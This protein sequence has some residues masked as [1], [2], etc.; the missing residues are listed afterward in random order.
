MTAITDEAFRGRSATAGLSLPMLSTVFGLTGFVLLNLLALGAAGWPLEYP[1]D[2]VYIHLAISAEIA[3]GG[4]GVNPGEAS[5]AASSI[6]YPLLLTPLAGTDWH[7]YLPLAWN[8]AAVGAG[9]WLWGRLVAMAGIEGAGLSMLRLL[10]A[11]L[12]PLSFNIAGVGFTGME[13][14]LHVTATL[15]VLVGLVAFL[16]GGRVG[17]LLVA[18]IVLGPALRFEGVAVSGIA[19]A[20]L[21]F[22]GRPAVAVLAGAGALAPLGIFAWVLMQFGLDPVP[23]SVQAKIIAGLTEYGDTPLFRR[24]LIVLYNVTRP[25]GAALALIAAFWAIAGAAVPRLR[26]G[27]DLRMLLVLVG[28]AGAHLVMGRIGWMH[29]YEIYMVVWVMGLSI[30]LAA[31]WLRRGGRAGALARVGCAAVLAAGFAHYFLLMASVGPNAA[32]AIR[33]QQAQ[34]AR[35]V[36]QHVEGVVAVNDL[37]WVVFRNPGRVLDLWGL[38]SSEALTLRLSHPPEGWAAPLVERRGAD[39]A[40]IY[41]SWLDR[42]VAPGWVRLGALV[43]ENEGHVASSHEVAFYATRPEAVPGLVAALRSFAPTLPEGARFD[44]APGL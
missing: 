8:F 43:L 34:M 12:G 7:R 16:R 15:A 38:A 41:D 1:L 20:V 39:L 27:A 22:S 21:L 5:S 6:L 13:H 10:L 19:C 31:P 32:A 2:D 9:A 23:N 36:D 14:A 3:R 33:L 18:G 30:I 42:A 35:F 37:G 28:V 29:R 25:A 44:L 40:M 11:A 26:R 4:Y 17:W 24:F